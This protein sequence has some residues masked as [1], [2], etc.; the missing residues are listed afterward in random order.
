[1]S[2]SQLLLHG[3]PSIPPPEVL[4]E[5]DAAWERAQ[6]LVHDELVLH[7]EHDPLLRR[8]WSELRTADGSVV[9][10]L[11]ASEAVAVA[12]GEELRA[13]ALAIA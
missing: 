12:C 8:A 9:R 7:F 1:M 13:T 10:R 3:L 6:R 11:S 4:D 5:V 2:R